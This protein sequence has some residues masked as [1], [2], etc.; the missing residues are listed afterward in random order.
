MEEATQDKPF[1]TSKLFCLPF[2]NHPPSQYDTIL[3]TLRLAIEKCRIH[4]Q[5]T[6]IV[7][8]DQPLYIKAK[9]IIENCSDTDF[10]NVVLRL[11]QRMDT[12]EYQRFRTE[13]YFTIGHSETFWAGI[14][15]MCIEQ[16]LIKS[17]KRC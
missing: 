8:F 14:W 3:T 17:M 10:C 6:I 1:E 13:E 16:V 5:K 4:E 9:E 2:I 7:T 12:C 15:F 11:D